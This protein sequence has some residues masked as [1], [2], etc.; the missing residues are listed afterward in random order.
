MDPRQFSAL[1]A[2][3]PLFS[4][5]IKT[6][7]QG[8]RGSEEVNDSQA[9]GVDLF[10]GVFTIAHPKS[11]SKNVR[12]HPFPCPSSANE[13]FPPGLH[14]ESHPPLHPPPGMPWQVTPR[15]HVWKSCSPSKS[16]QNEVAVSPIL[17]QSHMGR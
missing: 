10:C 16:L 7:S 6:W 3:L 17:R 15:S 8:H 12:F 2:K 9:Q 4:L 5:F 13:K 1:R 14:P 11:S